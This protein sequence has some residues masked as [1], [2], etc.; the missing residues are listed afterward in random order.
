MP[1]HGMEIPIPDAE[2]ETL[3]ECANCAK[4]TVV[5]FTPTDADGTALCYPIPLC[6]ICDRRLSALETSPMACGAILG[7]C[8]AMEERT[9]TDWL[10]ASG[11]EPT[12]G[13][14]KRANR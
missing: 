10:L 12:N 2:P 1:W 5:F 6:A 11:G 3:E 4:H 8:E 7:L 14:T 9:G 13:G